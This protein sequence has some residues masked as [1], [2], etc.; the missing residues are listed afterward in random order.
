MQ[1]DD[2]SACEIMNDRLKYPIAALSHTIKT[3]RL[4]AYAIELSIAQYISQQWGSNALR[5]PKQTAVPPNRFV[6]DKVKGIEVT[7]K[8]FSKAEMK[9]ETVMIG[10][11]ADHMPAGHDLAHEVG[12]LRNPGSHNKECGSYPLPVQ[13]VENLWSIAGIRAVIKSQSHAA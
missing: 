7:M 12:I 11:V 8:G 1:Q 6:H 5:R 4:P 3:T 2:T 9:I 13:I 10:M